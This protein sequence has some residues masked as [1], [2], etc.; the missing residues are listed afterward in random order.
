MLTPGTVVDRYEIVAPIAGGGMGMVYRVRQVELGSEYAMKV[1]LPNFA[2]SDKVRARFR[3]EAVVQAR[4]QHDGIVNVFDLVHTGDVFA[5]VMDLVRG[6]SLEHVISN[7]SPGPWP[8]EAAMAVLGPVVAALS[9][10]QGQ[11]IAHRDLKPA[12]VVLDRTS[13]AWPGKP[14]LT[15]FGLAKILSSARG[16]TKAGAMM[17]TLPYMAPEQYRGHTDVDARAD[18][19]SIGMMTWRLLSGRLPV[20]PEDMVAVADLYTGRLPLARLDQLGPPVSPAVADV[21]AH[22]LALNP[23][24]RPANAAMVAQ[25]LADAMGST[26]GGWGSP[27][28][29]ASASPSRPGVPVSGWESRPGTSSQER[30]PSSS[31]AAATSLPK[32]AL[33]VA[34]GAVAVMAFIAI[35]AAT[36]AN[37]ETAPLAATGTETAANPAVTAMIAEGK[38]AMSERRWVDA[39]AIYEKAKAA[40][41]V[42]REP[43]RALNVIAEEKANR[44][45]VKRAEA[46]FAVRDY[47]RS[48]REYRNIPADSVYRRDA[49]SALQSIAQLLELEGD[50][51][52]DDGRRQRCLARYDLALSTDHAAAGLAD[53]RRRAAPAPVGAAAGDASTA[54]T[55]APSHAAS[56]RQPTAARNS[57]DASA[58]TPAR[59][60]T[61]AGHARPAAVDLDF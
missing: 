4:L 29:P 51:A 38:K 43:V 37:E 8:A 57:P 9:F 30:G 59:Q 15:D 31:D 61:A 39:A 26:V 33:P 58:K 19:F 48:I 42:H 55:K 35:A 21:V 53:K 6:P 18:V 5:M 12:N 25:L 28:P 23:A 50:Q 34:G 47:E 24:A 41:P 16:M 44:E 52:C 13:T 40:D 54:A 49:R 3:Q 36:G 17:G 22:C 27:Q 20:N 32:W 7:E 11:G 1:L 14:R 46:A 10:A 2:A 56:V 60:P 45:L